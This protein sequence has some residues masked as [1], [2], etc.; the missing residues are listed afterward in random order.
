RW[1][2]VRRAQTGRLAPCRAGRA[3]LGDP[4]AVREPSVRRL[5]D[6]PAPRAGIRCHAP[7]SGC[8]VAGLRLG[9]ASTV[10]LVAASAAR[11]PEGVRFAGADAPVATRAAP[12]GDPP[13]RGAS[14]R[15]WRRSRRGGAP[16]PPDA[17]PRSAGARYLRPAGRDPGRP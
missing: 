15:G 1:P 10:R 9:G 17:G 13:A 16:L 4:G 12:A 6:L 5:H 2:V 11:G 8:V 14:P 7:S 3:V